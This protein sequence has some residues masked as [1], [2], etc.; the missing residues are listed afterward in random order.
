MGISNEV[1]HDCHDRGGQKER[2]DPELP[3]CHDAGHH[4]RGMHPQPALLQAGAEER[5]P[6]ESRDEVCRHVCEAAIGLDG[7]DEERRQQSQEP[8]D[9]W[10]ELRRAR[11]Q[12]KGYRLTALRAA[13]LR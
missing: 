7:Q 2:Q 13:E 5:G 10:H 4:D 8:A 6:H 3:D 9:R 11:N 1:V 12:R